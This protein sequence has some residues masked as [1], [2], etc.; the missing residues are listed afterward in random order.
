MWNCEGIKIRRV[1]GGVLPSWQL[2][3]VLLWI[4]LPQTLPTH[5]FADDFPLPHPLRMQD[6]QLSARSHRA[7]ITAVQAAARAANARPDIVSGLEDPMLSPSLDHKPL[8]GMGQNTSITIEQRFPLSGVR[9]YRRDGA[10]AEAERVQS[11]AD[12]TA[13]DIGQETARAYLML[14]KERQMQ[15]ILTEQADLASSIVRAA[16]ARYATGNGSQAEVLRA[17]TEQARL[18]ARLAASLADTAA[19]EAMLNT[20]MGREA[21][22]PVPELAPDGTPFLS[23]NP[24]LSKADAV[25]AA[26]RLRP[27]LNGGK[28]ATRRAA[29]EVKVM[30]SMYRPM[31]TVR[32]GMADTMAEGKGYMLMVGVSLPIWRNRLAAGVTESKAMESMAQADLDAMQRMITGETAAAWEAWRGAVLRY[33]S[34]RQ[35]VVPRATRTI[36][37]ALAAYGEGRMA[38]T[39]VLESAQALWMV[40]MELVDAEYAA[41]LSW[42]RLQRSIGDIGA[43]P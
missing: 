36:P 6:A 19:A 3:G 13:L 4:L 24:N 32:A 38:L 2:A 25:T 17:E 26:V 12:M 11:V 43:N 1:A 27:E 8:E 42:S 39:G 18:K 16:N 28:A 29:A 37:P 40:Q 41:G 21:A 34:M 7:E 31:A 9:G 15:K 30:E 33:E 35:E 5:S 10:K 22:L 20:S 14:R 23:Q